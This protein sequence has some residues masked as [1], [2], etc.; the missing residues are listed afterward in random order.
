VVERQGESMKG[1]GK[2]S[3]AT[4][5][6]IPAAITAVIGLT[7]AAVFLYLF[8][9]D[10][11]ATPDVDSLFVSFV[12]FGTGLMAGLFM[13]RSVIPRRAPQSLFGE[14]GFGESGGV[15]AQR[16]RPPEVP[17]QREESPVDTTKTAIELRGRSETALIA[18]SARPHKVSNYKARDNS[19]ALAVATAIAVSLVLG[20]RIIGGWE[21]LALVVPCSWL[22]ALG[23]YWIRQRQNASG[24]RYNLPVAGGVVLV[25]AIAGVGLIMMHFE[26]LRVFLGLTM[27][28]GG[29][30]ALILHR[31][32]QRQTPDGSFL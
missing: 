18:S 17:A 10:L 4:Q 3:T 15:S 32:R 31:R 14:S 29:A 13:L 8:V 9:F 28:A 2:A 19:G 7:I 12:V 26:F 11:L 30:I 16:P 5:I 25:M 23:L 24:A 27:G 1:P 6:K 20:G 22:V 21:F